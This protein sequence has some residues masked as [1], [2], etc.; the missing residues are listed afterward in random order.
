MAGQITI[1]QTTLPV[2]WLEAEVGAFSQRLIDAGA[3]CVQHERIRATY[4]WKGEIQSAEEWR[5]QAKVQTSIVET[6]VKIIA[7]NHPYETPEIVWFSA[8]AEKKYL[9]WIEESSV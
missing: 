5:L 3:G 9:E 2:E 8:N 4:R 1:I 6:V 7:N